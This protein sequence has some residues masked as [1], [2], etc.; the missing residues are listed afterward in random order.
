M[1]TGIRKSEMRKYY[2]K[3]DKKKVY[4]EKLHNKN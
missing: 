4:R 1:I 3:K 2:I